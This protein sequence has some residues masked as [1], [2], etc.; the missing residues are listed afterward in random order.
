MFALVTK[1]VQEPP[2]IRIPIEVQALLHEYS[3]LTP[4]ELPKELPPMRDIHHAI[5]VWTV[6]PLTKLR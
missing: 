4:E 3:D 1:Q 5:C 6:V 2:K